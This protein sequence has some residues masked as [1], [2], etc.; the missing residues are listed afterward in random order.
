[1][2][3]SFRR[4]RVTNWST[5]LPP[6]YTCGGKGGG[7]E[8]KGLRRDLIHRLGV[9]LPGLLREGRGYG[10][11]AQ[12]LSHNRNHSVSNTALRT[13]RQKVNEMLSTVPVT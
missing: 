13:E 6:S 2:A 3:V 7:T 8:G 10:L 1:M 4:K 5:L 11:R 9:T 12:G